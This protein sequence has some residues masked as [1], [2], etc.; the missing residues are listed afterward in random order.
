MCA[1]C[2]M[3]FGMI[4]GSS[5]HSSSWAQRSFKFTSQLL[6]RDMRDMRRDQWK[7][8]PVIQKI[9]KIQIPIQTWCIWIQ[10]VQYV[11]ENVKRIP[12]DG[13]PWFTLTLEHAEQQNKLWTVQGLWDGYKVELDGTGM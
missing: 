1:M 7:N 8:S 9:Q 10:H 2:A 6:R 13:S 4:L 3:A 5:N 12:T 11:Q